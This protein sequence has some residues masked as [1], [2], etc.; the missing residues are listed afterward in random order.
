MEKAGRNRRRRRRR[1]RG[2]LVVDARF[3]TAIV[4][5]VPPRDDRS[6]LSSAEP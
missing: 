5:A 6:G 1:R 2:R 4:S 3:V